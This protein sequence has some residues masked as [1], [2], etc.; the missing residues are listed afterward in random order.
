MASHTKP[1]GVS[2]VYSLDN[3]CCKRNPLRVSVPPSYPYDIGRMLTIC[4][5]KPVWSSSTDHLSVDE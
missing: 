2:F 3:C 5:L 1:H 4:P